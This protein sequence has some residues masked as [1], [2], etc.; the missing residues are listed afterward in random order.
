MALIPVL[1]FTVYDENLVDCNVFEGA[2][3]STRLSTEP[4]VA[5][6]PQPAHH[7]ACSPSSATAL[8]RSQ[9]GRLLLA[10]PSSRHIHAAPLLPSDNRR[11]PI[12]GSTSQPSLNLTMTISY[13][14]GNIIPD[15][16]FGPGPSCIP[17]GQPGK[18]LTLTLQ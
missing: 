12:P 6:E 8:G 11:E 3:A 15:N 4:N 10:V 2:I 13:R 14:S 17:Y 1:G 9:A 7:H 5:P 16:Q 18:G